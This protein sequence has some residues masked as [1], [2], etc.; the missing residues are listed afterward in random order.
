MAKGLCAARMLGDDDL[1]AARVEFCDNGVAVERLVGDQGVEGQS[2]DERRHA[3]GIEALSQQKHERTIQGR[4][5]CSW[6]KLESDSLK[7]EQRLFGKA[8]RNRSCS[9]ISS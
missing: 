1:G 6:L 2:L 8:L 4:N 7:I 5:T 3:H 9:A